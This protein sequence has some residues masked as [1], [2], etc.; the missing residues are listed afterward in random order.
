MFWLGDAQVEIGNGLIYKVT[1]LTNEG[2][3]PV[4]NNNLRKMVETN[5]KTTF[6]GRN[7]KVEPIQEKGVKLLSN[8]LGYKG[9]STNLCHL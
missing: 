1:R 4:N 2:C 7:M 6:D 8:I 9:K 3:N 5:I